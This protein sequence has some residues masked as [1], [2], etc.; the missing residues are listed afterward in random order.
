MFSSDIVIQTDDGFS[1]YDVETKE[2][3]NDVYDTV[4]A[5]HVW[6]GYGT[7]VSGGSKLPPNTIVAARCVVQGEFEEE[8]TIIGGNPPKV[9]KR[10]VNFSKYLIKHFK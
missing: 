7:F 3:V 2:L 5:S 4:I 8:F 1:I 6:L 9:L 10:G